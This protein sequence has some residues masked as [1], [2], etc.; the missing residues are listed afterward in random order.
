MSTINFIFCVC[1]NKKRFV[2]NRGA[3]INVNYNPCFSLTYK[4]FIP[5]KYLT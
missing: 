3:N 1:T 5:S 2:K 4:Q